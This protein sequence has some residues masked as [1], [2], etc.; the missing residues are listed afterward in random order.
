[1]LD[2]DSVLCRWASAKWSLENVVD[3]RF[4]HYE[5]FC[6]T[7]VTP[8]EPEEHE[9]RVVLVDGTNRVFDDVW[10]TTDLIREILAAASL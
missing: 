4:E 3:V 1:M 9:V 7:D 8:A 2:I 6:G 5:G 10:L